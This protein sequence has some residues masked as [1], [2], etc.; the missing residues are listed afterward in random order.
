[1][2]H[3]RTL[4]ILSLFVSLLA[5]CSGFGP[6]SELEVNREKWTNQNVSHYRFNLHIGCFCA[7]R[8]KMPLVIE[9]NNGEIISIT[10]ANGA[11]PS[12]QEMEWYQEYS[13]IEKVF[14]YL[15]K[16]SQEADKSEIAF[17][18]E[19]GIPTQIHIDWI[20]LAMDDEMSLTISNFEKLP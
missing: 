2:K 19:T 1:M 6:K 14:A 5:A 9:V 7:F 20:E 13:S 4:L 10:D 12:A 17:D 3:L 11:T 8:D 16:A 15:Q 18:S